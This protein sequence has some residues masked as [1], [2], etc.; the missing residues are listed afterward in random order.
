MIRKCWMIMVLTFAGACVVR[1]AIVAD[2]TFETSAPNGYG[3]AIGGIAAED[4]VN[5]STSMASG[6][7]ANSSTTWSSPAGN[8]GTLHSFSAEHWSVGDYFQFATS[9]LG[10]NNIMV[11][12]EQT[13]S[14]TGPSAFKL[15]Y[16][17]DGTTYFDISGDSY[18][19]G[20]T[21]WS[22]SSGTLKATILDFDVS[23][24]TAVNGQNAVYFR[25]IDTSTTAAGGGIVGSGGSSRVDDFEISGSISAVP[26]SPAWGGMAGAGLIVLCCLRAWRNRRS[27]E[28]LN[29]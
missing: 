22:T 1:G 14:S 8:S 11:T 21:T 16:S 7:H 20:T 17:T 2:W 4:G 5:A 13:S 18:T 9:T 19:V 10:Y 24:T 27:G 26:E 6:F 12:F 25:L 23:T 15:A 29:P 3:T 28:D